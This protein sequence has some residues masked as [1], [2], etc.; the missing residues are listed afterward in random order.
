MNDLIHFTIWLYNPCQHSPPKCNSQS[1]YNSPDQFLGALS[2]KHSNVA[3]LF[4]I[5][6]DLSQMSEVVSI[7]EK[8][9]EKPNLF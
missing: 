1:K 6:E 8:C 4:H 7:C 3:N 9:T 2:K 5:G